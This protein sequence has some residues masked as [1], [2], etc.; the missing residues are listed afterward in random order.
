LNDLKKNQEPSKIREDELLGNSIEKTLK[1][2]GNSTGKIKKSQENFHGGSTRELRSCCDATLPSPPCP[3][4]AFQDGMK[5]RYTQ[6][7]RRLHKRPLNL[8][9]VDFQ[10]PNISI[11]NF[12]T[13]FGN[14]LE[15]AKQHFFKF[16]STYDVFNLTEDNVTCQLFLQTLLGDALEWFHS[17]LPG[18]ITSWDVLETSFAEKFIPNVL[19]VVAHPPSPIWTQN[20]EVNDLEEKSNQRLE[21]FSESSHTAENENDKNPILSIFTCSSM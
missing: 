20:N 10:M 19:N 14:T 2:L 18:T 15:D 3:S 12:S 4:M 13:F 6:R 11:E 1:G 8:P 7:R 17:L 16:K 5:G 21:D 9:K